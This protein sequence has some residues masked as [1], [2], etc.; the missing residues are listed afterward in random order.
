MEKSNYSAEELVQIIDACGKAGVNS[1]SLAK[2]F[3]IEFFERKPEA[4]YTTIDHINEL[5]PV[6]ESMQGTDSSVA[7]HDNNYNQDLLD[8]EES[9]NLIVEDPLAYEDSLTLDDEKLEDINE[10]DTDASEGH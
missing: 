7:V 2:G 4:I 8:D 1:L 9:L 3:K 10:G 5:S 6:P